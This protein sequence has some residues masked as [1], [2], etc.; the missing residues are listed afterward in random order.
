MAMR[1]G[2][3]GDLMKERGCVLLSVVRWILLA[4]LDFVWPEFHRTF[5]V[6]LEFL[7]D[8]EV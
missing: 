5:E 4:G 1:G 7:E 8:A 6:L 3:V 2:M